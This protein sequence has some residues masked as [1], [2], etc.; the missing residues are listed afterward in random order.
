MMLIDTHTHLYTD[1]FRDDL[2]QVV[3]R[4][5]HVGVARALLPNVDIESMELLKEAVR[6]FP[7]FFT[8]MMGLHPTSVTAQWKQ[9]LATIYDELQKGTY[10]A[11]GE[12]GIDLY[13]DT[14]LENE[15]IE[16]FEEQLMWSKEMNLPV[17]IHSR[18]AFPQVIRSIKKVGANSLRGVF[19][20][21]GG[22]TDELHTI[23]E[24]K[25]FLIGING[26]VTFKNSGLAS[27]LSQG[28]VS[29][30]VLE[31]DAP[32]LSP[33]PKRGKRNESSYLTFILKKIAEIYETTEENI[34][35]IT[36]QNAV[37]LF[38]LNLSEKMD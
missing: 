17:S 16:A 3:E 28:D 21:F 13:W 14:S 6:R 32:Y 29:K 31:T 10:I 7:H 24:L 25:H 38:R 1:E 36:T 15:Q 8:T 9:Q 19:H 37:E 12:I 33:V 30:I 34:A 35:K 20:S 27:T 23:M 26:I 18:N 22:T 11:V 2:A 5:Q 4:A